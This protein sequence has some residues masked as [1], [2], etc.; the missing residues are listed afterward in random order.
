MSHSKEKIYWGTWVAHSVKHPTSVQVMI[1]WFVRLS[2]VSDSM[3]TAWSL[4]ESLFLPLCPSPD[5]AHLLSLS[6]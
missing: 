4:L 1:S 2:P 5:C 6:K 3:L